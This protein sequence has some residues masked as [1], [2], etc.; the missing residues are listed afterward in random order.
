[1]TGTED[2]DP[3]LRRNTVEQLV[4]LKKSQIY[5]LMSEGLF[6]KPVRIGKRSCAWRK[7]SIKNWIIERPEAGSF[8]PGN[9]NDAT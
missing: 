6:P 1:M 4:G 7:S 3:L 8:E 9:T 5:H 2:I